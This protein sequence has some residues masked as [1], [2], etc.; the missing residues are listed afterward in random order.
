MHCAAKWRAVHRACIERKCALGSLCVTRQEGLHRRL[1]RLGARLT[2]RW[3][4]ALASFGLLALLLVGLGL[5]VTLTQERTLLQNQAVTLHDEVRQAFP[6]LPGGGSGPPGN[7]DRI[8][9]LISDGA[10]A[11]EVGLPS[12]GFAAA[13]PT[14]TKRPP[15]PALLA[16][17]LPP[18]GPVLA[19]ASRD[20]DVH[21]AP[22][23]PD[24]G[25]IADAL[26]KPPSPSSYSLAQDT[27]GQR[28]L[29]V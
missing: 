3:R 23:T 6:P 11:P 7:T 25:A 5:L 28:Q 22:V 26:Q 10:V 16:T 1:G 27:G 21:P 18:T 19:Q 2:L 9:L 4:L 20:T 8:Y 14:Q 17:I 15:G 13:A 29:V 24:A 12:P